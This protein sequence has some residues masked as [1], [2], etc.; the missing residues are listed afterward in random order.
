MNTE[1]YLQ[2]IS[3]TLESIQEDGNP[4]SNPSLDQLEDCIDQANHRLNV[5]VQDAAPYVLTQD[6][7]DAP[8]TTVNQAVLNYLPNTTLFGIQQIQPN[9]GVGNRNQSSGTSNVVTDVATNSFYATPRICIA[10]DDINLSAIQTN[11]AELY[12]CVDHTQHMLKVDTRKIQGTDVSVN[13]GTKDNGTQRICIAENDVLLSQ[14]ANGVFNDAYQCSV[15]NFPEVQ[16]ITGG[17]NMAQINGVT[18]S[19]YSGNRDTGTQRVAIADDDINVAAMNTKLGTLAGAVSSNKFQCELPGNS[20]VLTALDYASYASNGNAIS[21]FIGTANRIQKFSGGTTLSNSFCYPSAGPGNM[22]ADPTYQNYT[23]SK[24]G[25]VQRMCIAT[26][27]VNMAAINT[28]TSTIAGSIASSKIQANVSQVG[29]VAVSVNSGVNGTGVQRVTI[30]TDDTLLSNLSKLFADYR[31]LSTNFVPVILGG[32]A[33]LSGNTVFY[34]V[35]NNSSYTFT[36]SNTGPPI[37]SAQITVTGSGS[38][39]YTG[40]DGAQAINYSYYTSSSSTANAAGTALFSNSESLLDFPYEVPRWY[41]STFQNETKNVNNLVLSNSIGPTYITFIPAGCSESVKWYAQ[42]PGNGGK[43]YL[44]KLTIVSCDTTADGC[45]VKIMFKAWNKTTGALAFQAV[46]YE[47]YFKNMQGSV[48]IDLSY[49]QQIGTN[50]GLNWGFWT[51]NIYASAVCMYVKGSSVTTQ[52]VG[53]YLSC[54]VFRS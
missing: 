4:V 8:F 11:T 52:T 12:T 10:T 22:S 20:I 7:E 37:V 24:P 51:S 26:D 39:D 42:V 38:K 23:G 5:T 21:D 47:Q 31:F 6:E 48:T 41:V 25:A 16:T 43:I 1:E 29:G 30:A 44:K 13:S 45:T 17:I 15:L 2:Q 35:P 36:E 53:V 33:V 3:L 28:S 54:N 46:L 34:C 49:L 18:T 14:L 27:D 50:T 32:M 9:F 19:V 40:V